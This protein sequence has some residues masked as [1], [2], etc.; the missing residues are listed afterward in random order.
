MGDR[1]GSALL[2]TLP[3][4][5]TNP[6]PADVLFAF[7][8]ALN[9]EAVRGAVSQSWMS[10][11]DGREWVDQAL[12]S[13]N[14]IAGVRVALVQKPQ[15]GPTGSAWL[16]CW[17]TS[18]IANEAVMGPSGLCSPTTLDGREPSQAA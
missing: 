12:A 2:G 13:Q 16:S 4:T 3:R 9:H 5:A 7:V 8:D 11:P 10:T 15:S 1:H 17:P 6:D 14:V 18:M